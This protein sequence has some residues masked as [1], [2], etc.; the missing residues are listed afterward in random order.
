MP[1]PLRAE[2]KAHATEE[3]PNECCGVVVFRDGIAERYVR[4][5]NKRASPYRYELDV[6]PRHAR[7]GLGRA[8]IEANLPGR[9][10]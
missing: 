5:R 2:L 7:K 6:D 4:G 1:E 8:L 3:A 9:K 10:A